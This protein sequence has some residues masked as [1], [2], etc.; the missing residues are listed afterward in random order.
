MK[1]LLI[2]FV[3][4]IAI[5]GSIHAQQAEM[6]LV[7]ATGFKTIKIGRDLDVVLINSVSH[8]QDFQFNV[9]ISEQLN[10]SIEGGT[11][12]VSNRSFNKK[13]RVYLLVNGLEKLV[14]G[15]NS[16]IVTHGVLQSS[17]LLVYVSQGATARIKLLGKVKAF[18]VDESEVRMTK[19][20]EQGK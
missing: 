19:W 15:Q 3:A 9:S 4:I 7:S 14:V 6:P 12:V 17:N 8:Q 10:M 18:P 13:A 1:K 2:A 16:H 20:S 5:N 11:L